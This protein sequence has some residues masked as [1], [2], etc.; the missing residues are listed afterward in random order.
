[1]IEIHAQNPTIGSARQ[2]LMMATIYKVSGAADGS[3]NGD[4]S[5]P[6]YEHYPDERR[7]IPRYGPQS[8]SGPMQHLWTWMSMEVTVK[9]ACWWMEDRF[10]AVSAARRP[11]DKKNPGS[12]AGR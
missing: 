10:G 3:H 6:S 9:S 7:E 4:E 1:M 2:P 11:V 12:Q 5:S 8:P